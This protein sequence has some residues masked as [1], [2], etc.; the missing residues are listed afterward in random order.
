MNNK[1]IIMDYL[2]M[3]SEQ[4]DEKLFQTYWSWCVKY[5]KTPIHIQQLFANTT[6]SN[7]WITEY[8]KLL[9]QFTTALEFLPKKKD[10]LDHHFYGYVVQIYE[11]YP[12]ALIEAIKNDNLKQEIVLIK[13][14]PLYHAN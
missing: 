1:N 9:S 4:Y 3:S 8:E 2:Q 13:N 14:L 12:K 11:I 6:I 5:G 10:L 7:W